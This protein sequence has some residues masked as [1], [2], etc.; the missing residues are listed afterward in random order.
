[1]T[2][3]TKKHLKSITITFDERSGGK[4][5][6]RTIDQLK[7]H[8][9]CEVADWS[10][11]V[12]QNRYRNLIGSVV[13]DWHR[14]LNQVNDYINRGQPADTVLE[15]FP[16]WLPDFNLI[17]A[18]SPQGVALRDVAERWGDIAAA[19]AWSIVRRPGQNVPTPH[20]ALTLVAI[21]DYRAALADP[22]GTKQRG[23]VEQLKSIVS[24]AES[25]TIE[26]QNAENIKA[27]QHE[28]EFQSKLKAA[29]DLIEKCDEARTTLRSLSAQHIA[30]SRTE[31]E[32][33]RSEFR[34]NLVFT[35]PAKLWADRG[36]S[37][38]WSAVRY[39][40]GGS[41]IA[42]FG[43]SFLPAWTKSS[44]QVA[45]ELASSAGL[46]T[47]VSNSEKVIS[48]IPLSV[49]ASSGTFELGILVSSVLLYVTILL[50]SIR[51]LVRLFVAEYHL[52]V[53]ATGRHV[54]VLTYL[55]LKKMDMVT[56]GDRSTLLTA[57]FRPTGDG[58][59]KDDG[60]PI[61]GLAGILTDQIAGKQPR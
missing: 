38:K 26:F 41:V 57:I 60:M 51:T 48:T 39:A 29:Q 32:E 52:W 3:D 54:M 36:K 10:E 11:V 23:L 30:N 25:A 6:F 17:S 58:L 61:F 31:W 33:L 19:Q 27:D 28:V 13:T 21:M 47:V 43:V 37:H 20:D 22:V 35:E 8:I 56:D 16:S 45:V 4:R 5:S 46:R 14:A 34:E 42:F 15:A 18:R 12:D 1:M 7:D 53:D 24:D 40:I 44:V 9:N 50:W 49:Q 2:S 59:V 55:A